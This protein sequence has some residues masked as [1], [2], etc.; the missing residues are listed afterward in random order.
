[1]N[2]L[3]T[4]NQKIRRNGPFPQK[5][6]ITKRQPRWNSFVALKEIE[7][8]KV[9]QKKKSSSPDGFTGDYYQMFKEERLKAFPLS[10]RILQR[11]LLSLISC[12][13]VIGWFHKGK[14]SKQKTYEF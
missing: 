6:Q 2:K 3:Y 13:I 12:N 10:T 14:K 4:Q 7:S 9:S 11:C 5:P 1:M 8:L